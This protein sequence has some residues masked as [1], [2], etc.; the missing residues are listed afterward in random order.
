MIMCII[1]VKDQPVPVIM[2]QYGI[3]P[4]PVPIGIPFQYQGTAALRQ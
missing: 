2:T 1:S 3:M 4:Y